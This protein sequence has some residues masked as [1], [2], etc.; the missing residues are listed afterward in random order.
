LEIWRQRGV[1]AIGIYLVR[2]LDSIG[3]FFGN[4]QKPVIEL[5]HLPYGRSVIGIV[6]SEFAA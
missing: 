5:E 1:L 3:A 4:H 2:N 6:E